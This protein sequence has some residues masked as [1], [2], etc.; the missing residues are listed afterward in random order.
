MGNSIILKD[1]YSYT[2]LWEKVLIENITFIADIDMMYTTDNQRKENKRKKKKRKELQLCTAEW[3]A[4]TEDSS[5]FKKGRI[6]SH[7]I[8]CWFWSGIELIFFV[9]GMVLCFGFVTKSVFI[10]HQCFTCC[11]SCLYNIE[12]FVFFHA[13]LLVTEDAQKFGRDIAKTVDPKCP[14]RSSTRYDITLSNRNWGGKEGREDIWSFSVCLRKQPLRVKKLWFPRNVFFPCL[15][16]W[17]S[18][19]LSNCYYLI[20]QVF[21]LLP[22]SFSPPLHEA[23]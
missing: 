11:W 6:G 23:G 9:T 19:Y 17:L 13:S 16:A 5:T 20:P 7:S 15:P 3:Q 14:K 10:S 4:L 2:A 12:A 8:H 1:F 18:L 21:S 22:F